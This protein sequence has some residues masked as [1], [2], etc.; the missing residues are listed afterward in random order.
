MLQLLRDDHPLRWTRPEL[1]AAIE[2]IE[3]QMLVNALALL[4]IEGVAA[5]DDT[6]IWAS[7][8]T[9]HLD[10]LDLISI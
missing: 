8:G 5:I 2:D 6:S 10:S 9:R 3:Q 7:Q 1:E 4:S